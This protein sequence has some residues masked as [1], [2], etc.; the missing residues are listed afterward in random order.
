MVAFGFGKND[1]LIS[2]CVEPMLMFLSL[3]KTCGLEQASSD[4]SSIQ[5]LIRKYWK[6]K[7]ML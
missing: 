2:K 7:I 5:A 4:V 6:K 1:V 3:R